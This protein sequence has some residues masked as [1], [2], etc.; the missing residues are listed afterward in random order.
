MPASSLKPTTIAQIG[1]LPVDYAKIFWDPSIRPAVRSIRWSA[2]RAFE[3]SSFFL[4]FVPGDYAV[5]DVDNAMSV[6]GD[7]M[8][9]RDQHDGVPLG[10][11]AIE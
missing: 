7:V 2:S 10:M 1:L 4:A 8:L 3:L 5:F 11:Q 6:F 9:V